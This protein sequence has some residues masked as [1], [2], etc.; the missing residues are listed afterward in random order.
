MGVPG[1]ATASRIASIVPAPLPASDGTALAR[2][3]PRW[4]RELR[5][6]AR[7]KKLVIGAF[8]VAILALVAVFAPAI[9]PYPADQMRVAPLYAPAGPN[10]WFGSDEFGRDLFSRIVYGTRISLG[11]ST[12]VAGS[13]LI[14]G[15]VLGV[16]AGL[17]PGRLAATITAVTDLLF[18]VPTVLL[19]LFAAAVYGV[20][21]RTVVFS[22]SIVYV[23]QFVRVLRGSVLSVANR[24]FVTAARASGATPFRVAAAHILPN[25]LSPVIVHTATVMSLVILDEA[26]LSF[27]GVGVQPPNPSWGIILRQ[28]LDYLSRTSQTTVVAGA[29]IFVAVFAFNLL[30][31]GLRD[32]LDPRLRRR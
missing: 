11:I 1:P 5:A 17:A 31:D 18:G 25:C 14:V 13:A 12:V 28:G 4:R 15:G 26:A 29:A 3:R 27:I 24:E 21:L 16:V 7:N 9:A 6:I 23:P 32:Q 30:A 22:L 2:R 19:A 20:G 8:L 10:L